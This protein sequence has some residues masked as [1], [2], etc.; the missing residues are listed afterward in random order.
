L[1]V[2]DF[3]MQGSEESA[4]ANF[5]AGGNAQLFDLGNAAGHWNDNEAYKSLHSQDPMS[6]MDDRFDIQFAS[7]E[8]FDGL[9]LEYIANSYHVFGNNGTHALNMPITDGTG[10]SPTVLDALAAASDHLPVV[11][12]YFFP[13]LPGVRIAQTLAATKAAEGGYYDT[14]HVVLDTVP[15]A[16][17]TVTVTPNAQV[18]VGNGAGVAK[19]LTFT[20]ANALTPQT[21][22]VNAAN[23][24]AAEGYHTGLITHT[25][26][27]SDANYH[28]LS[29][30]SVTVSIADND[31]PKWVINEIDT[32]QAGVDTGEFIEIYDGGVGNFPLTGMSLVFYSGSN[33]QSYA[34]YD[35]SGKQTDA[36]GFFVLANAGVLPAGPTVL[37]FS[38]GTLQNGVDAVAL[39]ALPASSFPNGTNVTTTALVDAVVYG[40]GEADTGLTPLLLAG[41][42]QLNE[43]QGGNATTNSLS[44]VPDGGT[45]RQ[46]SSYVAQLPTPGAFN[47]PQIYGIELLQSAGRIDIEEG[48]LTDSYQLALLSR[49]TANVQIQLT[50]NSQIDLGN[51]AGSAITLTFTPAN[52][53]IPQVITVTA[54]NDLAIEGNHSGSITHAVTSSDVHYNGLSI[55]TVNA[56]ITD[57]DVPLPPSIVISELMYNPASD[58]T[59]PGV[60]EWIEIVN[61]GTQATD[62]SGWRFSDDDATWGAIPAGTIL[63]PNQIAV[64]FDAAFTNRATFRTEWN[65]PAS[66]LVIDVSW[67]NLA[68]NLSLGDEPIALLNAASAQMDLVSYDDANPWPSASNGPS[69]YLKNLAADNNA[70]ANWARSTTTVKA[71]SPTGSTFSTSD[72][73]SPGRIFLAGDYNANGLVDAGDYVQWR[74]VVGTGALL[75]NDAIGG[76]IGTAHY[77]QWRTNFGAVGVP[78]GGLGSGSGAGAGVELA[79]GTMAGEESAATTSPNGGVASGGSRAVDAAIA[80]FGD[81][82]STSAT[83]GVAQ[84]LHSL[85]PPSVARTGDLLLAI[86]APSTAADFDDDALGEFPSVSGDRSNEV[87]EV[88][89]AL[90]GELV[91]HL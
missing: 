54:V 52:A 34:S 5:L 15:T 3:N 30:G 4:Y 71:I 14:Y 75:P 77:N 68:N 69:I 61:T 35:L 12:D 21:I 84:G 88:F 2:G 39:Y 59:S 26:A 22:I 58:E 55:G 6:T 86:A 51:G 62:I 79:A 76:T 72:V 90:T 41:Q 50:P 66:A 82:P 81:A 91:I 46:T 10:A 16:N 17:V 56:N 11:A 67:G 23:D 63:L 47:V 40:P 28:A 89:E 33:D 20:P 80:N 9:G 36:Y 7:G 48:G 74:K 1:F 29:L 83:S 45:Q 24:A 32:D 49:P 27:S 60:G 73:G 42:P 37:N 64:I 13:S 19:V 70:G 53:L 78:N 8:F 18:D 25:S 57:N 65:V 31:P 87:D 43:N 44:R 85:S 38:N